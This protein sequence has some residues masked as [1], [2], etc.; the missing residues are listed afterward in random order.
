MKPLIFYIT[1]NKVFM[2]IMLKAIIKIFKETF[3]LIF[4]LINTKIEH[5]ISLGKPFNII[6]YSKS[7]INIRLQ[8]KVKQSIKY[9]QG[10][11]KMARIQIKSIF[12]LSMDSYLSMAVAAGAA[13]LKLHVPPITNVLHGLALRIQ[14]QKRVSLKQLIAC[15]IN[16]Y[17]KEIYANFLFL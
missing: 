2:L 1:N 3:S 17:N 6:F 5:L 15:S 12:L 4:N 13:M 8:N 16:P 11:A 9:Q 10:I 7:F 14:L